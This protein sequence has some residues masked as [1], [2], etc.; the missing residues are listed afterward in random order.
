MFL[1][2]GNKLRFHVSYKKSVIILSMNLK[3]QTFPVLGMSCA[4]CAA[5]VEKALQIVEGV[6]SVNVNLPLNVARVEYDQE[7]CTPDQL[8]ESVARMGFELVVEE[9]DNSQSLNFPKKA[10]RS[11]CSRGAQSVVYD[12]QKD[13]ALRNYLQ[14]RSR[15]IGSIILAIPI[16][17]LS[18][19]NNLFDGQIL[20]VFF[21]TSW[22]L[23]KYGRE[24]YIKAWHLLLHRTSNMD[25]LVSL[26]TCVAYFFSCFNLF[27]SQWF[28]RHGVSPHL[29]F[30]SAA[31]ITAFILLGRWLEARA[32]HRTT[33]SLQHLIK[34][35]PQTVTQ[36]FGD[37]TEKNVSIEAIKKGDW[38][39]AH[40]GE[41]I[42]AD[43]V[44]IKGSSN[45]DE[46]MLSG[47]PIAVSKTKGSRVMTGTINKNGYL[48]Y[49]TERI[50]NDT[51]LSQIIKMVEEAQGSKVPMQKLVDKIA[52][53]FVPTIVGI[54]LLSFVAWYFLD[55]S[56]GLTH[57]ILALVSVLV[58]AC[59]CSLGLATPTAII[60]GIGRGAEKGILVKDATGLETAQKVDFVALD[61][62]GTLTEGH[63]DVI[64]AFF[65]KEKD[66]ASIFL[67]L[68]KKSEHPLAE[69]ICAHY[70]GENILLVKNF[71]AL[72]GKGVRG[73]I[74]GHPYFI[75]NI[76]WLKNEKRLFSI[77]QDERIKEWKE[78]AYTI[79]ALANETEVIALIALTD[80]I[81][82]TS[83]QAVTELKEMGIEVVILTGD[84][85]Q[86]AS[87]VCNQVGAN[88]YAARLLPT[89]KTYFIK[90]LQ[91]A[92]RCVAMVGD[93]IN[94]SAA[95][96]QADLSIAMGKGSDIAV[97]TAM[98]TILSSDLIKIPWAIR[99][100]RATIRTIRQNLFWAFF[101]NIISVPIAA[102]ILYPLCGFMLNP[103]IAGAAMAMSSVSVVG[104]SLR[105]FRKKF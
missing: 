36:R 56:D 47:E 90:R 95:L 33:K 76:D 72:N 14:L 22:S 6:V 104:N 31:V 49:E 10:T 62:T 98:M 102:G 19:I 58:I 13:E 75:G 85:E 81:K 79:V 23:W 3:K 26:S 60:V 46:S 17:I 11:C 8:Q 54:A 25:T 27:Y 52:A 1:S 63:P 68:E 69:S 55:P 15:A 80:K 61:K 50:G 24:F 5:H 4:S 51:L 73:E 96:A 93:G 35:Q 39:I 53:I 97:E 64:D 32:K 21:L 2:R 82:D 71:T 20:A 59:P 89:D 12:S 92:G 16:V 100:S 29:Y 43:G 77:K 28:I 48:I 34:L 99:L 38:L 9:G 42:A 30:D 44:V 91:A 66:A 105:L 41:R 83:R 57:G 45:V 7:R 101:Y 78:K 94:D 84:N 87:A 37:G 67:S 74:N 103:M 65:E 40:P 88:R 70:K 18:M 86:T